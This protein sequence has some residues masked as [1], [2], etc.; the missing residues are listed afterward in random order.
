LSGD[1]L[2]AILEGRPLAVTGE[3]GRIMV[4]IFTAIDRS[5][6]D[7]RPVR[8]PVSAWIRVTGDPG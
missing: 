7:R 6:R 1:E 2:P 4:T 3:D 5:Q 8:F